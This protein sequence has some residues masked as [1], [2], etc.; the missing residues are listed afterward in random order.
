MGWLIAEIVCAVVGG[1]AGAGSIVCG[2]KSAPAK[3]Q[4]EQKEIAKKS[5]N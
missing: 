1:I 2:I 3:A 5:K 4:L